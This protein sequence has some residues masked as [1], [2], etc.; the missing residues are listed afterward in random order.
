MR[1]SSIETNVNT[2]Y[3]ELKDN[4]EIQELF[5]V[6]NAYNLIILIK[7]IFNHLY[8]FIYRGTLR[9]NMNCTIQKNIRR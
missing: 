5:K 6:F 4:E 9:N 8:G 3:K 7:I 2:L 1:H